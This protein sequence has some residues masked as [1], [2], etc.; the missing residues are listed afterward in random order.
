[1]PK[2]NT[3]T[4]TYSSHALENPATPALP[5]SELR[6]APSHHHGA[7]YAYEA[8]ESYEHGA[9]HLSGHT[10]GRAIG[11]ADTPEVM[12]QQLCIEIGAQKHYNEQDCG[13]LYR[14]Q[15][16]GEQLG[17]AHTCGYYTEHQPY[18]HRPERHRRP[19]VAK[20]RGED[21]PESVIE[22]HGI[23]HIRKRRA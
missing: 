14:G 8:P 23:S 19:S 9:F 1:M 11:H 15:N 4:S 3:D 5:I 10:V 18:Q 20:K 17:R 22:H 12:S 13:H 21:S 7:L 6:R 2:L 16:G